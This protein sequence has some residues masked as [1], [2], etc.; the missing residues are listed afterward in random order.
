MT[1]LLPI[2][3]ITSDIT[4]DLTADIIAD[5]TAGNTDDNTADNFWYHCMHSELLT[6]FDYL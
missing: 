6:N 3:D 1:S 2:A 5:I 4:V